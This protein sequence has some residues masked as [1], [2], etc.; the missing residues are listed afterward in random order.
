MEGYIEF[1]D[2]LF[3]KLNSLNVDVSGLKLDHIAYYAS[4]K[5]DYD[6]LLPALSKL[7][8]LEHEAIIS[9]RRIAVAKLFAPISYNQYLI[10]AVELIEPRPAETHFSGWEHAEFVTDQSYQSLLETY[11]QLPWETGSM[12][13]ANFSHIT[14]LLGDN[15][16]V[17]FH[18]QS[19]LESVRIDKAVSIPPR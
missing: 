17:I 9:N 18:H 2:K 13:R 4:S 7:G 19:I 15:M 1:L 3:E 5:Q 14:A 12:D 8:S 6:Q 16:K 11:D 10:E